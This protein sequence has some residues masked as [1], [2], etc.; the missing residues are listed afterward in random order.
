MEF[1]SLSVLR[2]SVY[3]PEYTVFFSDKAIVAILRE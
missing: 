1:K 3:S 2:V